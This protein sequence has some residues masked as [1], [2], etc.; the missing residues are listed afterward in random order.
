M[1][2]FRTSLCFKPDKSSE[3]EVASDYRVTKLIPAAMTD[4]QSGYLAACLKTLK[5]EDTLLQELLQH[6]SDFPIQFPVQSVL[7]RTLLK[8]QPDVSEEIL[9]HHINSAYPVLHEAA[10][11]LYFDFLEYKKKFGTTQEKELYANMSIVELV[12][13]FLEKRAITFCGRFDSYMLLSGER[14]MGGWDTIG[15]KMEKPPLVL[16]DCLSYDEI[17]LSAFLALSNYSVFINSGNRRNCGIPSSSLET[18]RRHGVVVGIVGP[19]LS[20]AGVMDQHEIM[21]TKTQ[22]VKKNGYGSSL[23]NNAQHCWRQIWANFYGVPNLPTYNKVLKSMQSMD[24]GER[25]VEIHTEM[26]F[27]NNIYAKRISIAAELLLLEAESRAAAVNKQAYVHVVGFGLG[28]WKISGHQGKIFLDSFATCLKHLYPILSHV[29]DVNFAW[30]EENTCGGVGNGGRIG[31]DKHSIRILFSRRHPHSPLEDAE[32]A[33]KLLVVSYAWDGNS[34]PGN[35]FW[36]N[37]LDTSGDSANASSTQV[38]ELQN[39]HVNRKKISGRNL[40]V[41]CSEWGVVHV[42]EYSRRKLKQVSN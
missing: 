39:P 13:R 24:A 17:K 10:L 16:Q 40:H 8:E 36:I 38:S 42:E 3:P 35:E 9:E 33:N 28:V 34:L 26:V 2:S 20:H 21:V 6:S 18:V 11:T 22:N 31:D 41:A 29:S 1:A 4:L 5:L 30:F 27:D 37:Q 7:C 12:H 25:F 14:G 19:R 32:D 15:T 23:Q